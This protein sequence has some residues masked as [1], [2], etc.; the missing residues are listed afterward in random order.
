[1]ITNPLDRAALALGGAGVVSPLFAFSTS[2]N[3]NFVLVQGV[4]VFLL[5]ALGICAAIGAFSGKRVIVLV[6][7]SG[8]G[9]AALLQLAQFGR[10][11]NWLD[12]GGSTFALM[13]GLGI[14]LLM[15]ALA[16]GSRLVEL[17]AGDESTPP[18]GDRHHGVIATDGQAFVEGTADSTVQI[19]NQQA[20]G[21]R[22]IRGQ[23]GP[24]GPG[25]GRGGSMSRPVP[26]VP[27]RRPGRKSVSGR[28]E[29]AAHRRHQL[30]GAWE[31]AAWGAV[32]GLVAA[33]P[34]GALIRFQRMPDDAQGG[35]PSLA[36]FIL[37]ATATG[38]AIGLVVGYRPQGLA[39]AASGGV[40]MGLLGWLLFSLSVDPVLHGQPPTWSVEAAAGVYPA[41]VGG[42]LHG[43]VIGLV[44]HGLLSLRARSRQNGLALAVPA[45]PRIVIVGGGFAGLSA[46]QRFERLAL[47]G[48]PVD[49]T[50]ISDSN[51]LLFT[52]LLAE[53]ASSALE[54]THISAPVR[55]AVAHTR[56]RHGAVQ[57]IDT[58]GRAVR[59]AAGS[60]PAEWVPYDHLVLAVGS[61]PHFLDLPGVQEYASTLKYLSDAMSLREK[62]IGL[63]ERADHSAPDP[64]ERD[65][66]LTFVVAGGGFAGTEVIAELF[67]LV[68]G[69]LHYFPGI[70]PD[71]PRFV[72]VHSR[73]RI[74]PELS[75]E[76]GAYALDRLR[77][78]GI[79]FR[80]GVQVAAASACDV[81]LSDGDRIATRTFVWTAGNRP[82][83]LLARLG[84]ANAANGAL[85]TDSHL[86]VRGLDGVWAVG[87]CAQIPDLDSEGAPFPPTAQ[88]ALRQ[89]KVVADN[90]AAVIAGGAPAEFRFRTIGVLVGLGHR[91]AVA[92]I[93][94][95]RFSGLAAWVLWRGIYLAKL[96]GIEKR[97]RVLI[98]WML[99]LVF[100]RD[101]V[102]A[103]RQTTQG[104][105]P[106]RQDSVGQP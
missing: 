33:L 36:L 53:V 3:N 51:F 30:R 83:P 86:R 16:P 50:L 15:L 77:A 95:H 39:L 98:D 74:L 38:A 2:S 6:A 93:R 27:T 63:L 14:G 96:P 37:Y 57:D 66:L 1:M 24:N 28:S 70:T 59:L 60:E 79:E 49:V 71:E 78:R 52:P 56:F 18:V 81:L 82:S 41:L 7:G 44:I 29:L 87:D 45:L 85:F 67:D 69:V 13:L 35:V 61:V 72:L 64:A 48:V 8:F 11:T 43:G 68:H 5:P 12:G 102:L 40:L 75:A 19:S 97:V 21:Q 25:S 104:A 47:R 58:D 54:P 89:G 65:R 73:D 55:A 34:V 20:H 10:S 22:P 88:H 46:A 90:I 23:G 42:L 9:L 31:R 94:G 32:A 106:A 17:P 105:T 100:P 103:T 62:V 99:D 91:T 4:S 101:I 26:H 84:G 80:L 76:L 92:E